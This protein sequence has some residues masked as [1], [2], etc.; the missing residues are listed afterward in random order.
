[1][2]GEETLSQNRGTSQRIN[3]PITR[4]VPQPISDEPILISDDS[5]DSSIQVIHFGCFQ[6]YAIKISIH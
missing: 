2:Y 5:N 1:V 6:V 4:N 3:I